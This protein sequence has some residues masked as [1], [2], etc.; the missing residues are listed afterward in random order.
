MSPPG[1]AK[2]IKGNKKSP[3]AE[4]NVTIA[5][6]T[7]YVAA[8]AGDTISHGIYMFDNRL[9][10]GSHG[11]GSVALHTVCAIGDAIRFD[12]HAIKAQ[13][14]PID[15]VAIKAFTLNERI[16]FTHKS[17]PRPQTTQEGLMNETCWIGQALNP[18]TQVYGLQISLMVGLLQPVAYDI[19]LEAY[20]T[21]R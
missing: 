7:D 13:G 4:T 18:G 11:A 1:I 5:I 16:I 9:Q 17:I 20:I 12:V 14:G 8:R 21:A 15:R 6:D 10:N 2:V 3:T 19:S